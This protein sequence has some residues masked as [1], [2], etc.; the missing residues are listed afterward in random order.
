M[1]LVQKSVSILA[2]TL[3]M[4]GL[5][6]VSQ[7]AYA[8]NSANGQVP[9]CLSD[10]GQNLSVD[11]A[12]VLRMKVNTPNSFRARALI[13]GVVTKIY[14]D[15]SCHHHFQLQIGT[16]QTD[17]IEVIYNEEFGSFPNFSQGAKVVAC[18]DYI[19][20]NRQTQYP[21]SP[22]GAIIHWIHMAPHPERH[23]SGYLMI[24]GVMTGQ[25]IGGGNRNC[26]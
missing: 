4:F 19:T 5:V 20:S 10:D 16:S 11:N 24:N 13:S 17:T 23:K 7:G 2:L 3:S 1:K 6:L 12:N 25:S 18:G 14:P 26:N 21:A 9:S 15:H 22:D 8:F